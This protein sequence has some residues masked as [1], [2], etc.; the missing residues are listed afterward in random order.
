MSELNQTVRRQSK[1]TGIIVHARIGHLCVS[2]DDKDWLNEREH[3]YECV[4][5]LRASAAPMCACH[6]LRGVQTLS[7]LRGNHTVTVMTSLTK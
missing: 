4:R 7:I 3:R 6:V 5:V 2:D 1:Q